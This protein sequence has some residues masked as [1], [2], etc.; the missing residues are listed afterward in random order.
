MVWRNS[1]FWQNYFTLKASLPSQLKAPLNSH[2]KK[3]WNILW[4][5]TNKRPRR[6]QGA[7]I[8]SNINKLKVAN[9]FRRSRFWKLFGFMLRKQIQFTQLFHPPMCW[10]RNTRSHSGLTICPA[11]AVSLFMSCTKL[12]W[13]WPFITINSFKLLVTVQ[14]N[15]TYTP[16]GGT[17]KVSSG[18]LFISLRFCYLSFS[19]EKPV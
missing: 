4:T 5:Q 11:V 3:F 12:C 17:H 6:D 13:P 10:E 15:L 9:L 19:A 7:H 8:I 16:L 2:H 1:A 14:I 18:N